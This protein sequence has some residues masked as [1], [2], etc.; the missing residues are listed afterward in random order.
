MGDTTFSGVVR[1]RGFVTREDVGA[2]GIGEDS[3]NGFSVGSAWIDVATGDTYICVDDTAGAAVWTQT[4]TGGGG[5]FNP[6][7]T[8]IVAK[9]GGDEATIANGIAAALAL[10]PTAVNP[11]TIHIYPGLYSEADFVI[12]SFVSLLGVGQATATLIVATTTTGTLATLSADSMLGGTSLSGK[13]AGTSCK[14]ASA[15][16]ASLDQCVSIDCA[17][18]FDSVGAGAILSV[19]NCE[20]RS[21]AFGAVEDAFRATAGGVLSGIGMLVTSSVAGGTSEGYRAGGVGSRIEVRASTAELCEDG[22]D[23]DDGAT[24]VID[25]SRF[26]SCER[27][28]RIKNVGAGATLLSSSLV[29]VNSSVWDVLIESPT[30]TWEDSGSF[31]DRSKESIV[32]GADV[33]ALYFSAQDGEEALQVRGELHVGTHDFPAESAFG[34]GDS[35]VLGMVVQTNTNGE[36]GT[37]VDET[38]DAKS[39]SGSSF[40][41][42]P[43]LTSNNA[44]YWGGDVVFPG[45]KIS[46]VTVAIALGGGTIAWEYWNGSAWTV[47][48]ILV[49]D[50]D[51]PFDAHAQAAFLA[52]ADEQIRWGTLTGWATKSLNGET[53]YWMRVRVVTAIATAPIVEKT[54]LH[55]NRTEINSEGDLEFFGAAEPLR[56]LPLFPLQE[57]DGI[58]PKD[59]TVDFS[60]N[61]SIKGKKNK[62]EDTRLDATGTGFQIVAGL[63]TSRPVSLVVSWYCTVAVGDVELEVT[64]A[65][66]QPGAVLDG[67]LPDTTQTVIQAVPGTAKQITTST[68]TLD[69][70]DLVPGD[71]VALRIARDA[72]VGN[73]DDTAAGD[74]ALTTRPRLTGTFWR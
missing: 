54:K 36:A 70:S 49:T 18:G 50:A 1:A 43:G 41:V 39:P 38:D 5:G 56:A 74:V 44:C 68:F 26:D 64:G 69:V 17:V 19:H 4:G 51:A 33:R 22:L 31:R 35:H 52:T 16:T 34:G 55:T 59:E 42:F 63:D 25:T 30:S 20:S 53:K 29:I 46:G 48:T 40:A 73:A 7:R 37:W 27:G 9:A 32:V 58:A 8:I 61:I 60:T 47:A 12:P 3:L 14:L 13:S 57:L 21:T 15:G 11:V 23:L 72:Q 6:G 71:I 66:I 28:L 67:T 10:T 24:G 45:L 62:F 65:D 2:P